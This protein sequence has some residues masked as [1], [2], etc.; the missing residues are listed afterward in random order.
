MPYV[1]TSLTSL[2]A[3]ALVLWLSA[4]QPMQTADSAVT[5][6]N[7]ALKMT[8][9]ETAQVNLADEQMQ[10]RNFSAAEETLKALVEKRWGDADL[11]VKLGNSQ[12]L[13]GKQVEA[14]AAYDA[15]LQALPGQPDALE[16]KGIALMEQGQFVEAAQVLDDVLKVDP[17]RWKSLNA[18]GV[19]FAAT[20]RHPEALQYYERALV[21]APQNPLVQNN[22]GLSY[23]AR[24]QF[25]EAVR[26]LKGA[27]VGFANDAERRRQAELNLSLVYGLGGMMEPADML[28]RRN[29]SLDKA[30]QNLGHF[31]KMRRNYGLAESFIVEALTKGTEAYE[32]VVAVALPVSVTPPV[33]DVIEPAPTKPLKSKRHKWEK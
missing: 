28:L 19:A 30:A 21:A 29:L 18:I 33:V 8:K 2:I 17:T 23:A 32:N 12:R 24:Q 25:A 1:W 20:G 3:F 13:Q 4:C 10:A 7:P 11:F 22:M 5:L 31:A 6:K 27:A 14:I 15:A 26:A 9:E 16:G